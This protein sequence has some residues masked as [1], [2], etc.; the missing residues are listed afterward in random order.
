[1]KNFFLDRQLNRIEQEV[2][3]DLMLLLEVS[4]EYYS[5]RELNTLL[6]DLRLK[7]RSIRSLKKR[8]YIVGGSVTLW[9]CTAIVANMSG[10]YLISYFFLALIPASLFSFIGGSMFIA[11]KYHFYKHASSI[12]A[13]IKQE[14]DRRRKESS[15]F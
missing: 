3:D 13:I 8:L 4:P 1:M 7:R 11:R 2:N 12:E 10:L 15:I 5:T 14:L 9:I 6:R